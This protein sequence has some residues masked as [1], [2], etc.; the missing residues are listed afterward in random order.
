MKGKIKG[1]VKK[2]VTKTKV[3][4]K[5]T[6]NPSLVRTNINIDKEL[7]GKA[8]KLAFKEKI[9]LNKF[10]NNAIKAYVK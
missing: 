7:H 3:T 6:K 9:S 8:K 4:K 1:N 2:H 5:R 10:I